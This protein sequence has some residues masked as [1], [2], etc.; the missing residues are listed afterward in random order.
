[1]ADAMHEMRQQLA[2]LE[3]YLNQSGTIASGLSR[4]QPRP[5]SSPN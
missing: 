1:L 5:R 3:P 2:A 4:I